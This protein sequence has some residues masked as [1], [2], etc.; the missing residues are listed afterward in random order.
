[1]LFGPSALTSPPGDNDRYEQPLGR[2]VARGVNRDA[3]GRAA[4]ALKPAEQIGR[5]DGFDAFDLWKELADRPLN[6]AV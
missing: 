4:P 1:M 2:A 6:P 3:W 5:S